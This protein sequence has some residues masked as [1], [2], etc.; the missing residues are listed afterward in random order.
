MTAVVVPAEAWTPPSEVSYWYQPDTG[1][2]ASAFLCYC[3]MRARGSTRYGT[4]HPGGAGDRVL[5]HC[6]E[7]LPH[8][9]MIYTVEQRW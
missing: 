2:V 1:R 3:G 4:G 8:E 6:A 5:Y 9:A 7:H